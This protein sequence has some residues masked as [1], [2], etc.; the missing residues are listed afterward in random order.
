M[1][2][3]WPIFLSPAIM[4]GSCS[5]P[6]KDKSD[7]TE[8]KV[9]P[10]I[11]FIMADD[12]GYND[13]SCYG[14]MQ[15]KTPHLDS[16]ATDGIK[17][18]RFY[19][20]SAVSTPSRASILTGC[21]PL[22]FDI[23]QYF[24]RDEYLTS[25]AV[26]IPELL[27]KEGYIS[28]HVGK[29][30]LGG[31]H[32]DQ[33]KNRIQGRDTIP[34]PLEHGFDYYFSTIEGG[35]DVDLL[36]TRRVYRD[37]GKYLVA[38]DSL[39]PPDNNYLTN[40]FGNE[41]IRLI[42]EFNFKKTPFFINLWFK[43]PH[44]PYEPA[45]EPHLSKYRELNYP[46]R[47]NQNFHRGHNQPGDGILYNS[48]V[49]HMDEVIGK[50]VSRLK[51]LDIYDNTLIIFTSDNG[52]SYRGY[53]A[54][55]KGGK[56][57]LHEGGIRVP[58]IATWP[59]VIPPGKVSGELIHGNDMLPTFCNAAGVSPDI[60]EV[61]GISLLHHFRTLQPVKKERTLFWQLDLAIDP[62]GEVWYPQPGTK[63]EPFATA[64]VMKGDWKLLTDSLKPVILYNM[65]EDSL[66][67]VN[68][69]GKYP[70]VTGNLQSELK[71]FFEAER[72]QYRDKIRPK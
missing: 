28:A 68:L 50:I 35:L 41:T 63:P 7:K 72:I 22:R 51:E 33:V 31:L 2:K 49:S 57:D 39:L 47:K 10:N 25:K 55:F 69:I 36:D 6:D 19:S 30:H 13:L 26:M 32:L 44:T 34:G 18:T 46:E 17:F 5:S 48:M 71:S 65:T 54:P 58:M 21:Y 56:A 43:T 40:I 16:L 37:G 12:L 67:S 14:S 60:Y 3:Y 45:P 20:A 24:P 52:P 15:V 27:K 59:G 11:L 9:K 53:P 1:M 38:N 61:D 62:W 66:E 70:D 8:K 64:A 29:W 42:E 4:M 23:R